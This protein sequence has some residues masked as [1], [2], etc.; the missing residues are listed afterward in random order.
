MTTKDYKLIASIIN[1]LDTE[2]EH[3]GY[4]E[5]NT[6]VKMLAKEFELRNKNFDRKLFM[7]ACYGK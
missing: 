2:R 4:L 1:N 7:E 5:V 6:L 3:T